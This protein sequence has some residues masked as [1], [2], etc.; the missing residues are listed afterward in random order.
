MSDIR[1]VQGPTVD[2]TCGPLYH[3]TLASGMIVTSPAG[4]GDTE[5]PAMAPFIPV[6]TEDGRVLAPPS[7]EASQAS[8]CC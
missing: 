2:V 4:F 7:E 3:V 6:V 5:E 8:S 1:I